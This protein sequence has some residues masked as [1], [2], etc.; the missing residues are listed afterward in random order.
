MSENP[1]STISR[2]VAGDVGTKTPNS[3]LCS[4]RK[5][6]SNMLR[7]AILWMMGVPLIVVILI[8]YFFF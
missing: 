8:W 2:R 6:E 3:A 1:A 7:A 5:K 4:H